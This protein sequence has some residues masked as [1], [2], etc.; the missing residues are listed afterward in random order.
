MT[1]TVATRMSAG[2]VT[3][4]EHA[5]LRQVVDLVEGGAAAEVGVVDGFGRLLGVIDPADHPDLFGHAA[6]PRVAGTP[7]HRRRRAGRREAVAGDLMTPA[8]AVA[9]TWPVAR[10]SRVLTDAGADV[11]FVVDDLGCVRGTIT[12][13]QCR[14]APAAPTALKE[15]GRDQVRV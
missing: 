7:R 15:A 6:G 9:D 8:T 4:E 2:A 14:P 11:A 1:L 3:V 12:T 5:H 10:A 13:R